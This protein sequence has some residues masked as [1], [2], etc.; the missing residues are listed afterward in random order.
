MISRC[1]CTASAAPVPPRPVFCTARWNGVDPGLFLAVGSPPAF[2]KHRT[3]AEH[4]VRTARCRGVAPFL[5][6]KWM[7]A[8]FSRRS[9]MV[10]T[11]LFASQAGELMKPSAA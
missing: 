9:R 7:L 11:C 3:A 8:P 1:A 4:R 6:G 2:S 10:S 5:S